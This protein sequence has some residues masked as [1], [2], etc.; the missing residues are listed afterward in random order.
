[1]LQG[2]SRQAFLSD[3]LFFENLAVYRIIL[4]NTAESEKYFTPKQTWPHVD[5]ICMWVMRQ[6]CRHT[7]SDVLSDAREARDNE[8]NSLSLRY[9]SLHCTCTVGHE[10]ALFFF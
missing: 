7:Q 8:T 5:A 2:K 1:M 3:A 6:K 10:R 4:M 9:V